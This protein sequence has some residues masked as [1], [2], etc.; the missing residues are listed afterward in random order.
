MMSLPVRTV[1]IG[2]VNRLYRK[3]LCKS[4]L[5]EW[6]E[7][8]LYRKDLSQCRVRSPRIDHAFVEL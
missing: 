6:P 3:S 2:W 4:D 5:V 8:P 1:E 7:Q